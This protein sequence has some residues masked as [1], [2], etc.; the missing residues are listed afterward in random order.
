MSTSY[1]HASELVIVGQVHLCYANHFSN[2]S[3]DEPRPKTNQEGL[4]VLFDCLWNSNR[5]IL[6]VRS[7]GEL[8]RDS[9]MGEPETYWRSSNFTQ[10]FIML[11]KIAFEQIQLQQHVIYFGELSFT[12]PQCGHHIKLQPPDQT[13]IK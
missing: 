3:A 11:K 8:V 5:G 9:L 12:P 7:G 4:F 2:N 6:G 13:R 10:P 1:L